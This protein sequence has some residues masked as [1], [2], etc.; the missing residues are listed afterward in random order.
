VVCPEEVIENTGSLDFSGSIPLPRSTHC[1]TSSNLF[2]SRISE[3]HNIFSFPPPG[4]PNYPTREEAMNFRTTHSP[5]LLCLLTIMAFLPVPAVA[6][7]NEIDPGLKG[8]AKK[9]EVFFN[10]HN[11]EE[12]A[13]FYAKTTD[14]IHVDNVPMKSKKD[15]LASLKKNF[16]ENPEV[17]TKFTRIE[18]KRLSTKLVIESGHWENS[19]MAGSPKTEKG[20]YSAVWRKSKDKWVIVYERGWKVDKP[21]VAKK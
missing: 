1:V 4:N 19:K 7:D 17:Q 14:V 12:I 9:Y 18:Y 11:A 16:K 15:V 21:A 3:H 8:L 6:E 2:D 13:Q 10:S 5:P 20:R